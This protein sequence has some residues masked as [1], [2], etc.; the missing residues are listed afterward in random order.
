M[1]TQGAELVKAQGVGAAV[2][3]WPEGD[4]EVGKERDLQGRLSP[5]LSCFPPRP[6]SHLPPR[7]DEIGTKQRVAKEKISV[8][9]TWT[10]KQQL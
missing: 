2:Q 7:R 4:R 8:Y 3:A 10:T 6:P 5:A 1:G 9:H